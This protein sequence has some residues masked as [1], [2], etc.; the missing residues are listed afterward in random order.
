MMHINKKNWLVYF[1]AVLNIAVYMVEV[2][3]SQSLT[4]N[5]NVLLA[6]GANYAPAVAHG[7]DWRLFT[8]MFLHLSFMHI[9]SNILSL[10][11]F[12]SVVQDVYNNFEFIVIYIMSGIGGNLL[13]IYFQPNTISAGASTAIMGL[14]GCTLAMFALPKKDYNTDSVVEQAIF[15]LLLNTVSQAGTNVD[16]FGHLGGAITGFVIGLIFVLVKRTKIK[17]DNIKF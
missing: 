3:F 12:S 11:V 9:V 7:Q 6:L 1:I 2:H 5:N 14:V 15:L 4:I 13:S 17:N 8:A 16:I 10:I